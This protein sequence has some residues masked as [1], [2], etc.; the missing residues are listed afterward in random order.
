MVGQGPPIPAVGAGW[1]CVCG[2][3]C[4]LNVLFSLAYH[5]SSCFPFL[6]DTAQYRLKICL[7]E[8]LNPKQPTNSL[9]CSRS[10]FVFVSFINLLERSLRTFGITDLFGYNVGRGLGPIKHIKPDPPVIYY[11]PFQD[12]TSKFLNVTCCNVRVYMV[13][14]NMVT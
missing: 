8:P 1:V 2:G 11:G 10:V 4:S 7:K 9:S 12:G 13:F 6:W 5:I 14:S 3:G